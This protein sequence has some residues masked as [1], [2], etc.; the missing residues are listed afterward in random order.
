MSIEDRLP[1]KAAGR[2]LTVGELCAAFDGADPSEPVWLAAR[3]EGGAWRPLLGVE[4]DDYPFLVHAG[5]LTS[6]ADV[7]HPNGEQQR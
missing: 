3:N 2:T 7:Y 1:V 4:T 5:D 6:P